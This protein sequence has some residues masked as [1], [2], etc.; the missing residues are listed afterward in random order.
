MN[1]E[2]IKSIVLTLLVCISVFLTFN[3]W[4]YSPGYDTINSDETFDV[5]VGDKIEEPDLSKGLLKPYELFLS[6]R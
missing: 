5:S 1:Y 2:K 4:T 6:C 3:L